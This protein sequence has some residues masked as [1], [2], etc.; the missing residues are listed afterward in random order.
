MPVE[1]ETM[2]L[3][4][5]LHAVPGHGHGHEVVHEVH[6]QQPA[7]D[8]ACHERPLHRLLDRLCSLARPDILQRGRE[9]VRGGGGGSH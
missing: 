2:T 9:D 8:P 4:L 7:T 3:P 1:A 5:T 6:D